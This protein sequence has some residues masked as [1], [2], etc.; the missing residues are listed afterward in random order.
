L[1]GDAAAYEGEPPL[2]AAQREL[3]EETGYVAARWT[4][5]AEAPSSAGL[6]SE[7]VHLFLARGLVAEGPGGGDANEAI[8]HHRIP[9]RDAWAWLD[10]RRA[11]GVM[12][13]HRLMLGICWVAG[14]PSQDA[15]PEPAR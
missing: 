8:V 13:D 11:E 6:T 5:L 15:A 9:L 10:A 3:L 14:P 12:V 1:A 7:T 2:E 4:W